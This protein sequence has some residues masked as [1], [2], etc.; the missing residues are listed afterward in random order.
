[1]QYVSVQ[2]P[3]PLLPDVYKLL[4][5]KKTPRTAASPIA[6]SVANNDSAVDG[7]RKDRLA[8]VWYAVMP[9]SRAVIGT[10]VEGGHQ[11]NNPLDVAA[12]RSAANVQRVGGAAKSIHHQTKKAGL[13]DYALLSS[14]VVDGRTVYWIEPDVAE[15]VRTLI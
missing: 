1:M 5:E 4:F 7:D 12:L 15:F 13:P 2:I 10:L 11:W 6:P 9:E 3:E 8:R 14:R